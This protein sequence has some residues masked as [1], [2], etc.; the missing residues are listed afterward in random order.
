MSEAAAGVD[1]DINHLIEFIKTLGTANS[2]GEIQTTFGV[3]FKD[4]K[5]SNTLESLAGTL[6]AA[7]K[8]GL[9]KFKAELLLQ[10]V[11]D[12]EVITLLK[13]S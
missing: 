1:K 9:V 2:E 8:K 7:K 10:G 3:L 6:K 11:S 4:D 13:Q 12:N 5:L